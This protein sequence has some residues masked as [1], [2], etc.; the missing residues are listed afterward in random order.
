[1]YDDLVKAL[2]CIQNTSPNFNNT[3]DSNINYILYNLKI[4]HE[5]PNENQRL[6]AMTQLT[7]T[8]QFVSKI[9]WKGIDNLKFSNMYNSSTVEEEVYQP[10]DDNVSL[11]S[12]INADLNENRKRHNNQVLLE[13]LVK[14]YEERQK[15]KRLGRELEKALVEKFKKDKQ[16]Q[17]QTQSPSPLPSL[18]INDEAQT[19]SSFFTNNW[20]K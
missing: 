19:P 3:I 2:L 15:R 5:S 17:S 8:L 20:W 6:V 18:L 10:K 4:I 13:E 11:W 7:N 12:Q 14:E 16:A 9:G 1:M